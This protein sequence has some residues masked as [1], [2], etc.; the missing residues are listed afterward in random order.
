MERD[1]YAA[2]PYEEEKGEEKSD[3]FVVENDGFVTGLYIVKG[4]VI[5]KRIRLDK[6]DLKNIIQLAVDYELVD[7]NE[8][9]LT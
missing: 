2:K 8:L 5:I 6:T 1:Y 4:S 3:F 7:L 9:D